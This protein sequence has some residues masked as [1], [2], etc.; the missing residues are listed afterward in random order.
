MEFEKC[1]I[2]S[3]I[4]S[5]LHELLTFKECCGI[6]TCG[7]EQITCG[8]TTLSAKG[9]TVSWQLAVVYELNYYSDGQYSSL[10]KMFST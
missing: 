5:Y 8:A 2:M 7:F 4:A 6:G 3:G 9:C 10:L 1:A